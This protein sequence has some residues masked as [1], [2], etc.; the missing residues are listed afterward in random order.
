MLPGFAQ[1]LKGELNMLL[2]ES[3]N[4]LVDS[5]RRN[6]AWIGGSMFAS[7]STFENFAIART[8]YDEGKTDMKTLIARRNI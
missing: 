1:R 5:Q 2:S 4:T 3:V 6:A 8:E 7:M